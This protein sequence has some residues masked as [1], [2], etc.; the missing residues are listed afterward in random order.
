MGRTKQSR[1]VKRRRVILEADDSIVAEEQTTLTEHHEKQGG[2]D[3]ELEMA[4]A[5]DF[6]RNTPSDQVEAAA[7]EAIQLDLAHNDRWIHLRPPESLLSQSPPTTLAIAFSEYYDNQEAQV[8]PKLKAVFDRSVVQSGLEE[9]AP[10][11]NDTVTNDSVENASNICANSNAHVPSW[12]RGLGF[13]RLGIKDFEALQKLHKIIKDRVNRKGSESNNVS[14]SPSDLEWAS[15]SGSIEDP[16]KRAFG[17]L[18]GTWVSFRQ[19]ASCI[20]KNNAE[21]AVCILHSLLLM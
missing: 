1:P 12:A 7:A 8:N 15:W 19:G 18:P 13:A 5:I 4:R 14:S 17:F 6:L 9:N 20:E 10:E 16:R 11:V 3:G 21:N 2:V